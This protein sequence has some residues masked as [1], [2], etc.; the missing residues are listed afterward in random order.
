MGKLSPHLIPFN[1]L[2]CIPSGPSDLDTLSLASLSWILQVYSV[3]VYSV[4]V[5]SVTVYSVTVTS[6]FDG[7]LPVR[8]TKEEYI[9][10]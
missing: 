9:L 7:V 2:G 6:T 1:S 10:F 8:G 3:T 5:Y 4:T